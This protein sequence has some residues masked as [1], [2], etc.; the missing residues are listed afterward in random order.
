[1]NRTIA[2]TIAIVLLSGSQL[3]AVDTSSGRRM[4]D[5]MT[6]K[7]RTYGVIGRISAVA[8]FQNEGKPT[9]NLSRFN[10]SK[11]LT[12]LK[13]WKVDQNVI[14]GI[15]DLKKYGDPLT[16]G[17]QQPDIVNA[18]RN[19]LLVPHD[20]AFCKQLDLDAGKADLLQ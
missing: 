18:R 19:A 4:A 7:L 10:G 11:A 17:F 20:E 8:A 5:A 1:M 16:A 6:K 14:A 2:M 15:E 9:C 13:D 3:L 12:Y